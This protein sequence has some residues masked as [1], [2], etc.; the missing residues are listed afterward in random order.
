M[1]DISDHFANVSDITDPA[2]TDNGMYLEPVPLTEEQK[3][4]IEMEEKL[5]K[6]QEEEEPPAPPKRKTSVVK[7]KEELHRANMKEGESCDISQ[8]TEEEVREKLYKFFNPVCSF[9]EN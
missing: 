5:A 7:S 6:Q 8:L 4:A 1:Q 9:L 2:T 3:L